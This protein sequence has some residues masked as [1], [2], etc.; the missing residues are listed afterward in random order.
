M[1]EEIGVDYFVPERSVEL[2]RFPK[3]KVAFQKR[4]WINNP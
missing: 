1:K 2:W 3:I 4:S